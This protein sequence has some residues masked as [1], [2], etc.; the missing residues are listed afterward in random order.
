M[1]CNCD[2]LEPTYREVESV[3]LI[4]L[5]KEAG[6][7]VGKND[8][9]YGDVNQVKKRDKI[10]ANQCQ[11]GDMDQNTKDILIASLFKQDTYRQQFFMVI[12]IQYPMVPQV[13]ILG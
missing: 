3:K 5:L 2:H 12:R 13:V 10:G 9:N 8:R 6:I 7:A 4:K 1:P 11:N